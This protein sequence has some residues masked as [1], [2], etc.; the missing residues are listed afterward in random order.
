MERVFDAQFAEGLAKLVEEAEAQK[1]PS[2]SSAVPDSPVD[3][4]LQPAAGRGGGPAARHRKRR[5]TAS[6]PFLFFA[7]GHQMVRDAGT[8]PF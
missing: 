3:L 8:G 1:T 7:S 4:S 6:R 5:R 2:K